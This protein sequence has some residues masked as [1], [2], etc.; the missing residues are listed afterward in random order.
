MASTLA[1]GGNIENP[2]GF[3]S[4]LCITARLVPEPDVTPRPAMA[5]LEGKY[6]PHFKTGKELARSR[7]YL[8]LF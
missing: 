5:E 6:V 2:R 1:Q 4:F 8:R 3:G 7:Q